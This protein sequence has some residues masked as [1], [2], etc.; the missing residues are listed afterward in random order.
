[1]FLRDLGLTYGFL[2]ICVSHK[3]NFHSK[4]NAEYGI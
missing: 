1:M 2:K 3:S 4:P